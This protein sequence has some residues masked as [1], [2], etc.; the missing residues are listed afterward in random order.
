M[1][2]KEILIGRNIFLMRSLYAITREPE[3]CFWKVIDCHLQRFAKL[4]TGCCTGFGG[5]AMII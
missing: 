5:D 4:I 1:Y 2:F 3:D